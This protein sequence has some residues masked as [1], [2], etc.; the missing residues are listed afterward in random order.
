MF[1]SDRRYRYRLDRRWDAGA[2]IAWIMLNPSRAD[3]E[4]DDPT[5]RRVISFSRSWGYGGCVV[6]N[7]LAIC[8]S[9][10]RDL[11]RVDDQSGERNPA[12]IRQ[13]IEDTAGAGG[14]EVVVAW[15][16]AGQRLI[17]ANSTVG[18]RARANAQMAVTAWRAAGLQPTNLGTT[19]NGASRHP[20]YVRASVRRQPFADAVRVS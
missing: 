2:P 1:S 11:T 4:V 12:A 3:A 6:V 10:P 13:A 17:A 18:S 19:A 15:G 20:L 16:V 7:L 5:I 8:S 9:D 14:A